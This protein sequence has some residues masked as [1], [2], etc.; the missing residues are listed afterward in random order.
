MGAK[1]FVRRVSIQQGLYISPDELKEGLDLDCNA[2]AK[3]CFAVI[4]YADFPDDGEG[5]DIPLYV[6][7]EDAGYEVL[8]DENYHPEALVINGKVHSI[9]DPKEM[10]LLKA[11]ARAPY[12]KINEKPWLMVPK[13][14]DDD[15][16]YPGE[17]RT[18]FM[19][20]LARLHLR[21]IAPEGLLNTFAFAADLTVDS[22]LPVGYEVGFQWGNPLQTMLEMGF[23]ADGITPPEGKEY[24]FHSNLCGQGTCRLNPSFLQEVDPDSMVYCYQLTQALESKDD[25][26]ESDGYYSFIN[27]EKI[28]E[29]LARLDD[30]N[31]DDPFEAFETF[32][33]GCFTKAGAVE[34]FNKRLEEEGEYPFDY[35]A[36]AGPKA[37]HGYR[38]DGKIP[39][40][41]VR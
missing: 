15:Y 37:R 24:F 40:A 4:G 21:E 5:E 13:F 27:P 30:W 10:K 9:F 23:Y 18:E 32:G 7:D 11:N 20:E 39:G 34:R 3:P 29:I 16:E 6:L 28:P 12:D 36:W 14:E 22:E 8:S 33:F 1:I 17:L 31:E 19:Y 41:Y 25:W 38:P 26:W 35:C 2:V